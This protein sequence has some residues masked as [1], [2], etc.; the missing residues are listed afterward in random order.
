M[1]D[2]EESEVLE[3]F[4]KLSNWGRWGKDDV[5]GTL[6]FITPEKRV[7]ASQLVRTGRVVS[8]AYDIDTAPHIGDMM[9]AQRFMVRTGEGA[10]DTRQGF[11]WEFLGLVYHG[12]SV[13]HLDALSHM[14]WDRKL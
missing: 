13:T 3:Y 12:K 7:A 2:P 10:W 1:P 6:N 11:T 4:E 5:L 9:P 8:C 14:S